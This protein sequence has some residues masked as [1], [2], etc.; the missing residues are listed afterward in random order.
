MCSSLPASAAT[1]TAS[2]REGCSPKAAPT[3]YRTTRTSSR[4]TSASPSRRRQPLPSVLELTDVR[5]GYGSA[6][7]LHGISVNVNEGEVAVIL[8]ANGVGKTTMLRCVAGLLRPWSG[9]ISF[10]GKVVDR[11]GAEKIV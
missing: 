7:V 9:R 3:K 10:G 5:A 8:G 1:S 4:S 2:P 11:M 6:E